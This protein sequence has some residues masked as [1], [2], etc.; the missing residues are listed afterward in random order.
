MSS[1]Q[2]DVQF[3]HTNIAIWVLTCASGAFLF[4]RLWCRLNFSK[5]WW[6]DAVLTTSWLILL[7]AA[8]LLSRTMAYGYATEDAQRAFYRLQNAATAM[9]TIATSWTKV[10]FA[11]TLIRIVRNR[12]LT[13]FLGFVIVTA[14]LI[15]VPGMLSIWIPACEDPRAFL[16]PQK[17]VCF[18]LSDLRYLG[19][20]TIVYGGVI[21]ILLALFPWFVI[22]NLL[23][24]TREKIGLTVAMSLGALTGTIVILRVFFQLVPK[25]N[26]YHFMMFMA[27]FNYLE[28]AVTIIAQ[29]I[30][31][32]RVL[33][34]SVKRGTQY[35]VRITSP[36][37]RSE[38]VAARC[39]SAENQAPENGLHNEPARDHELLRVRVDPGGQIVRDT[40]QGD[41]GDDKLPDRRN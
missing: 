15:L 19:G 18:W 2:G 6:D 37:S 22:R 28:P 26:D 21:D 9:T 30:P 10:A 41:F 8:A 23:L 39:N 29:T 5:L 34:S 17:S 40:R 24:E 7:V 3:V 33:L 32:F 25:D 1:G 4:V 27:I 14:N 16:R 35:D 20:T 13:L 38:L 12:V 31:M 36:T 11:I